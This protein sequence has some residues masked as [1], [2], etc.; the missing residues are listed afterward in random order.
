MVT[1]MS[2]A[3]AAGI[4]AGLPNRR[5]KKLGF[6]QLLSIQRGSTGAG[7][8]L[9]GAIES[10]IEHDEQQDKGLGVDASEISEHH[11]QA[12]LSSSQL[13]SDVARTA[14]NGA[15]A[16]GPSKPT[17]HIPT[18]EAKAVLMQREYYELYPLGAYSDPVTYVRTSKTVEE[19]LRGPSYILDEDDNDW[20]EDRNKK[21]SEALA[22]ALRSA[23]LP[24]GSLKGKGKEKAREELAKSLGR[25]NVD[26][27]IISL[28]EFEM[29]FTVFE[30][31]TSEKVPFAHLDV[32]KLPTLEDLLPAFEAHSSISQ[33]AFPELPQMS[34]ESI[35][36]AAEAEWS[37][38][39]P[40]RN[41]SGLADLAKVIYPWW[42][43]RKED[44][45]GKPITPALNFDE[46][47]DDDPYVCFRRRE[48][49]MIRKTRKTDAAHL[50]KFIRLR[51]ELQQG[52]TLLS[53]LAQREKTKRASFEQDKVCFQSS[54][55]LLE[56]KRQWNIAGPNNGKEDEELVSGDKRDEY[57]LHG[58]AGA[59]TTSRKKR[60][61]EEALAAASAQ[62]AA[63]AAKEGAQ[64]KAARKSRPS[65]GDEASS[66]GQGGA[67]ASQAT[68]SNGLGSAILDRV[69]A[70]QAYI[71]REVQ[72][73][74]ESDV[75]WEEGS[76]AAF[77]PIPAPAHI[78]AFRPIDL[79]SS[80]ATDQSSA[81]TYPW[82][83]ASPAQRGNQPVRRSGRPASF[84]RRTGRGGRTW[85]DR[86]L[87]MPS[88]VPTSLD[89]W[90]QGSASSN[91]TA[92][93][94]KA[95][96]SSA[97][98][99]SSKRERSSARSLGSEAT[100]SS[101]PFAFS[102][103]VRP[104]LLTPAPVI[105]RKSQSHA[106]D[107]EAV[108]MTVGGPTQ[109]GNGSDASSSTSSRHS[110]GSATTKATSVAADDVERKADEDEDAADASSDEDAKEDRMSESEDSED[111]V[112]RWTRLQERWRYD[113]ESGRWAGLGLCGLGGM[114]DD[115]EAILDDFDQRF[116]RYR[117]NLLEE[118]DLS[119]LSTDLSNVMQ[120]QAAADAPSVLPTGYA[121]FRGET[122]SMYMQQQ[123]VPLVQQQAAA[124][125]AAALSQAN[126][127]P[128]A[129][130]ANGQLAGLGQQPSQP[131]QQAQ[132]QLA[133]QQQQ[134]RAAQVQAQALA[135]A[136]AAA[137]T[138]YNNKNGALN[139]QQ[140]SQSSPVPRPRSGSKQTQQQQQ[141]QQSAAQ[142]QHVLAQTLTAQNLAAA[143]AA[144]QFGNARFGGATAGLQFPANG[145]NAHLTNRTL[146][147][148]PVPTNQQV[149]QQ[150]RASPL[151]AQNGTFSSSP[152]Q[153]HTVPMGQQQQQQQQL[154]NG[155]ARMNG[156]GANLNLL[157]ANGQL[158]NPLAAAA[159]L[160]Q[161]Q[162]A[163]QAQQGMQQGQPQQQT[164][165][166]PQFTAQQLMAMQ[167]ALA[168][169][170]AGL[171]LKM[172][173]NR[174]RA[175]QIAQQA[176]MNA[177]GASQQQQAGANNSQAAP[178]QA[179]LTQTQFG[180]GLLQNLQQ[181]INFAQQHSQQQQQ[182]QQHGFNAASFNAAT[183]ASMAPNANAILAALSAANQGNPGRS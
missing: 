123:Q 131:L 81:T 99:A 39:N 30:E 23:R 144:G 121:I 167:A 73:K 75:G 125:Q 116:M 161:A 8:A 172:P 151:L 14:D 49:K 133:L 17:Y 28:D 79:Q 145:G 6:K 18:P 31:F 163:L 147:S 27:R 65:A 10:A 97:G 80:D 69:S 134:Q 50:E 182:Q 44:R 33:Q 25:E 143:M 59:A 13:A 12:A 130:Q 153:S 94:G 128:R 183:A 15:P 168:A 129:A 139:V 113:D 181:Q 95:L 169:Q 24:N 159:A 166:A 42:K 7:L 117:M 77:Q 37:P 177:N 41:L 57:Q 91:D 51:H 102:S 82:S 38:E 103:S 26:V 4:A 84:R 96:Q 105:A 64:S 115:D 160:Q 62:N 11:L 72:R 87:P 158:I 119:K 114:E 55:E 29:V 36:P 150:Q 66:N 120:A 149:S 67:N 74:A 109:D 106:K 156:A 155:Q 76:D 124:A 178:T 54:R 85:L 16:S 53:L 5:L 142:Q 47:K 180:M 108:E 179:Q 110:K 56:V 71:E 148:S 164:Q 126:G 88:P 78:R 136:A 107:E 127:L 32:S 111:E 140:Q 61:T 171:Q 40:F 46:S 138:Q 48:V 3:S 19:S 175:L 83:N 118:S 173:Q 101:G 86:K 43:T 58:V 98:G 60:K 176:A 152:A 132:M 21:A 100:T 135:A 174:A 170:N 146:S 92:R 20:L 52:V 22:L 90:K 9:A 93:K 63:A 162:A 112:E 137:N 89:D 154:A 70:V 141:Q 1:T 157:N 34:W 35:S 2:A 45:E 68:A 165:P 122:P 104:T